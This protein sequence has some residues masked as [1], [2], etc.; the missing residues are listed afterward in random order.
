MTRAND[1]YAVNVILAGEVVQVGV[2]EGE[3]WACSPMTKKSAGLYQLVVNFGMDMYLPG[4]DV[5]ESE[6]SLEMSIVTQE[7]HSW[8]VSKLDLNLRRSDRL[9]GCNVITRSAEF[10]QSLQISLT[11]LHL[12][13]F[14]RQLENL[15]RNEGGQGLGIRSVDFFSWHDCGLDR[16]SRVYMNGRR[17]IAKRTESN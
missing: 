2:D 16:R 5:I 13:Q 4:L 8:E 7:D 12:L 14:D 9:T 10:F 15:I 11:D 1:V 3:T 17:E 6:I